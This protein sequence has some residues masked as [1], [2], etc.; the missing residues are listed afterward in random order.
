MGEPPDMGDRARCQSETARGMHPARAT[1][2]GYGGAVQR[3]ACRP[4][5]DDG[6]SA[7]V[8]RAEAEMSEKKPTVD[9]LQRKIK[10]LEAQVEQLK[11]AHHQS[12]RHYGDMLA[13]SVD[14]Q[15]RNQQ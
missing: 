11:A 1:H 8:G 15:M 10:R 12:M 14:W 3:V 6:R 5:C 2:G 13:E 9:A 7:F 4:F